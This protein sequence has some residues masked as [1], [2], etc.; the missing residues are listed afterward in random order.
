MQASAYLR[1]VSSRFFR[2]ACLVLVAPLRAP[3]MP[4]VKVVMSK[5]AM[6][7]AA[8]EQRCG[9]PCVWIF[10]KALCVLSALSCGMVVY[11]RSQEGSS[12]NLTEGL[13]Q[14]GRVMSYT[15]F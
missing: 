7:E 13:T 8:E 1:E 11:I 10:D 3:N 4:N 12:N 6:T 9:A 5:S 2:C 14:T 15:S